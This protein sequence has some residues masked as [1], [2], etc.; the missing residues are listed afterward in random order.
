MSCSPTAIAYAAKKATP[1][2]VRKCIVVDKALGRVEV[3]FPV[4]RGALGE[5][6]DI[7]KPEGEPTRADVVRAALAFYYWSC[8]GYPTI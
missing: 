7:V 1:A 3:T 6:V 4:K 8:G 2:Y 5:S